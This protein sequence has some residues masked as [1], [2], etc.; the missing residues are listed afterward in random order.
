MGRGDERRNKEAKRE[1]EEIRKTREMGEMGEAGEAGKIGETEETRE[2][3]ITGHHNKVF[4]KLFSFHVLLLF[5]PSPLDK[6]AF[7]T[8][9][10]LY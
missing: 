6:R 4:K 8:H 1:K 9:H 2:M 7:F 5:F 10:S 3:D